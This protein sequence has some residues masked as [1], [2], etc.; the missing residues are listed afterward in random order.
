[1]IRRRSIDWRARPTSKEA[2]LLHRYERAHEESL[3]AAIRLLLT[4]ER[5]GADL[6]E[7]PEADPEA[8]AEAVAVPAAPEDPDANQE[9]ATTCEELASVGAAAPTGARA[10]GSTG[11]PGR[12]DGP[13]GADPGPG[14]ARDRS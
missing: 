11:S 10:G 14:M 12:H 1:M 4:L 5:S 9:K 8:A 13:I 2:Q 3:R 6:P 7:P